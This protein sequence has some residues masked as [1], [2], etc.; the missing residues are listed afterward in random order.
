MLQEHG[1]AM[2]T[3]EMPSGRLQCDKS[4]ELRLPQVDMKRLWE[5][6]K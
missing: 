5:R 6:Q 3:V 2:H 4:R 1:G